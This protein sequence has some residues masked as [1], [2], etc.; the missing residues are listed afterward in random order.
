MRQNR[1]LLLLF[2]MLA[3]ALV[4]CNQGAEE[5][6]EEPTAVAEEAAVE[7]TEPAEEPTAVADHGHSEPITTEVAVESTIAITP[8][9][10]AAA[11]PAT[12]RLGLLRFSDNDTSRTGRFQLLL[13]DITPA[14]A[15]THYE[16]W[17]V[18]NSLNAFNLGQ[19]AADGS[20]QFSSDT[21]QNLLGNFNAAFISIEPDGI[22][23]GEIGAIAFNGVIP[24]GSLLHIRHIVTAFPANP[25]GK[26]FLIGAEEQL[27]LA[28]EHADLLQNELT[29]GN[30]REARRHAE[31]VVNIL[32]GEKGPSF[33]DL[34]G[35]TIAQ[36]P[37]DGFGVRAYLEGAKEHAELATDAEGATDEVKLHAGHVLISS[38][39]T[40]ARLDEAIAQALRVISSDST[41]EAQPAAD[42]LSR[43]LEVAVNGQDANGDGVIAP[44]LNEGTL[45]VAYEH[46]L[47]MGAFE[48]F[49]ADETTITAV[50]PAEPGETTAEGTAVAPPAAATSTSA[51]SAAPLTVDMVNFVYQPETITVAAGASV[52]WIN[53][54]NGPR[55]SAT[56][57]DN[58]FD[59]GLFGAGEE[60]SLTFNTPGTYIYYCTLHGSP[61]GSGMAATIV[62]TE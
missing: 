47:F 48:F 4:A 36:N 42:E 9:V 15:G 3:L 50:S 31:H 54:D 29:A 32:E 58:S 5:A 30:L 28:I 39:N 52:T 37:G 19:F 59:T 8:T 24:A 12:P 16:L 51:A 14:P 11:A 26:A 23:H 56:A 2:L 41:T 22:A 33:G 1:I 34:D 55:H 62:V 21:D 43:L 49:T 57:A 10:A 61:D 53:K 25:G 38:D 27:A 20:V 18:D 6:V 35:D 44:V 40:Q 13:A 45:L 46:A 17:L 7:P 60:A